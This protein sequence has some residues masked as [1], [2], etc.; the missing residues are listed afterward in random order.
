MFFRG[1]QERRWGTG[2]YTGVL[3]DGMRKFQVVGMEVIAAISGQRDGVRFGRRNGTAARSVEWI[4]PQGMA[5][6]C[7]VD[8][9]LVRSTGDEVDVN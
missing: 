2:E 1:A 3:G 9:D 8:T 4:S 5:G 6:C 7:Q